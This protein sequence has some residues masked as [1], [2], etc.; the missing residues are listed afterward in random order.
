MNFYNT[1]HIIIIV[2]SGRCSFKNWCLVDTDLTVMIYDIQSSTLHSRKVFLETRFFDQHRQGK[3]TWLCLFPED[4]I[5]ME[6]KHWF[7]NL[8][9]NALFPTS[10]LEGVYYSKWRIT[11]L[12]W[13]QETGVQTTH[14]NGQ[15][16]AWQA[17]KASWSRNN[18]FIQTLNC[19]TKPSWAWV[20]S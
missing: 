6:W 11:P 9:P 10:A 1:S 7:S 17:I 16:N 2:P 12:C 14:H 18:N 19:T 13:I 20:V 5:I 4:H 3:Q 15:Q 8:P